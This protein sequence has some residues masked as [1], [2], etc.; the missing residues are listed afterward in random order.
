[1]SQEEDG[2]GLVPAL[3]AVYGSYQVYRAA[4]AS[5]SGTWQAVAAELQLQTFLGDALAM[6]AARALAQQRTGLGAGAEELWTGVP[7]GVAAGV[8]AGIQTVAE[9]LMWTD[10]HVDQAQ[11]KDDDGVIPTAANPPIELGMVAAQAVASA[12][13][14]ACAEAAGWRYKIW[15]SVQDSRVR[16]THRALHDV[17]ISLAENF[18]T[19]DGDELAY[20]GDPDSDIENRIGCRCWLLTAR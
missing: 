11:T 3:L 19:L 12:A 1:M 7:A 4:R 5:I 6:I 13:M 20:P 15:Q 14:L 2:A 10:H 17:K 16:E 8:S 18:K 9:A